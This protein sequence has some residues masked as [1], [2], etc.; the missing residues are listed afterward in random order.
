MV[1]HLNGIYMAVGISK[2]PEVTA[3]ARH[4]LGQ[5]LMSIYV[6]AGITCVKLP[7]RCSSLTIHTTNV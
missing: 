1:L 3:E 5:N 6:H 4:S 2:V 7:P